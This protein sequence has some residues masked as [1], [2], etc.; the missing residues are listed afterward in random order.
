MCAVRR[1]I[2]TSLASAGTAS[3]DTHVMYLQQVEDMEPAIRRV[4]WLDNC[5]CH[6]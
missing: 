1:H 6:C 4:A 2:L 5:M 3:N